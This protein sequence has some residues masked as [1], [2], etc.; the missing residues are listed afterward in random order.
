M[1]DRMQLSKCRGIG[2]RE[3]LATGAATLA[4]GVTGYPAVLRA[5]AEPVKIGLIHPVSGFIAFSGTQ[6]RAGAEMA[7]ADINA[8]GGIKSLGGAKIEALLADSQGKPEIGAAEHL[9]CGRV[10]VESRALFPRAARARPVAQISPKP[11]RS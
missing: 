1:T 2:R 6:C 8:A 11:Q 7:I 9:G 4:L 5:Q 10:A 3:L